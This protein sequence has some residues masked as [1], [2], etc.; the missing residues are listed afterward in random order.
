MCPCS[1]QSPLAAPRS[2]TRCSQIAAVRR[3]RPRAT[4]RRCFAAPQL[5]LPR[6]RCRFVLLLPNRRLL[7]GVSSAGISPPGAVRPGTGRHYRAYIP[8]A[9][10]SRCQQISPARLQNIT[11][12]LQHYTNITL[13]RT[14]GTTANVCAPKITALRPILR[15]RRKEFFHWQ[16]SIKAH[17]PYGHTATLSR[18]GY[19]PPFK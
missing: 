15:P 13:C 5:C 2:N 4:H 11:T 16:V 17:H 9:A 6:L 14:A 1:A 18:S 12:E 19:T 7:L 10:G 8:P 3:S